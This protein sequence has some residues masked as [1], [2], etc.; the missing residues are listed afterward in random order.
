MRDRRIPLRGVGRER[1]VFEIRER[2]FIRRDHADPAAGLDR[3]VAQG[4]ARLHRERGDGRAGI[5]ERIAD[6]PGDAD[7]SDER[8]DDILHRHAGMQFAIEHDAHAFLLAL[9]QRLRGEDAFAFTRA[10]AERHGAEGAVRA[11]VAVAANQGRTRQREAQFRPDDVDDTVPMIVHGDVGDGEAPRILGQARDLPGSETVGK[12][13]GAKACRHGMIG[14]G[15]VRIRPPQRAIFA[16]QTGE[17]LRARDLLD[18]MTIDVDQRV[19][20]VIG[21]DD[22]RSPNLVVQRL[23]TRVSRRC[24]GMRRTLPVATHLLRKIFDRCAPT[25]TPDRN[26]ALAPVAASKLC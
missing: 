3:H 6:T 24:H 17:S 2:C 10:D 21:L 11:G 4:H 12:R 25:L 8:E 9:T 22:M 13:I 16:D 1:T 23:P 14:D 15:D 19:P 26:F 7:L 5:F 20:I 18:Q